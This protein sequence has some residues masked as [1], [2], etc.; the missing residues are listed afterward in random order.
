LVERLLQERDRGRSKAG[1]SVHADSNASG[2][3]R[4][5]AATLAP[6]S[7]KSEEGIMTEE[8]CEHCSMANNS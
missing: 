7:I 3:A 5:M 1:I 8:R 4:L 6:G 2:S